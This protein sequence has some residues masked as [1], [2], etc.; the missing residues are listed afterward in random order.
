MT[1]EAAATK[2]GWLLARPGT[3]TERVRRLFQRDLRGELSEAGEFA[4]SH[5]TA[6]SRIVED[7][8]VAHISGSASL[9]SVADM[10]GLRPGETDADRTSKL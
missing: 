5:G 2:L 9:R 7:H 3:T 10:R 4:G 6:I 1:T 8:S